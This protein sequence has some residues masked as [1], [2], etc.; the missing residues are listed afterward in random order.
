MA[1]TRQTAREGLKN[2]RHIHPFQLPIDRDTR[3]SLDDTTKLV[4]TTI[5]GRP[6]QQGLFGNSQSPDFLK[7]L[8]EL[9]SLIKAINARDYGAIKTLLEKKPSAKPV[10]TQDDSV[11]ELI[12]ISKGQ[13]PDHPI[14]YALARA[15]VVPPNNVN[16]IE[17]LV[18][19]HLKVG[20]LTPKPD[21][22][23]GIQQFASNLN[24]KLLPALVDYSLNPRLDEVSS[25]PVAAA[26]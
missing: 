23:E 10:T 14:L 18:R 22:A 7:R 15:D 4:L 3:F 6:N 19:E 17:L 1:L 26:A 13:L 16:Y 2:M 11:L 20:K 5:S 21:T 8:P 25:K 12:R 9:W 24:E